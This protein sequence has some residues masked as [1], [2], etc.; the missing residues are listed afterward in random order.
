MKWFKKKEKQEK[1]NKTGVNLETFDW[2]SI[3]LVSFTTII[4]IGLIA[5]CLASS[6]AT[7][8]GINLTNQRTCLCNGQIR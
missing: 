3:T 2:I 7:I 8:K 5:M 1:Q 4:G 6:Y